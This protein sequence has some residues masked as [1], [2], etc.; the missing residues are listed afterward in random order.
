MDL[1]QQLAANFSLEG[2]FPLLA[3]VGVILTLMTAL[4]A[5]KYIKNNKFWYYLL[6]L[7]Y[8]I[9]TIIIILTNDWF[10]FLF[11]WE[12]VTLA[13]T[14]M[15]AWSDWKL[16]RQYFVIQ[17]SGSSIL[18][19]A[20]LAANGLGYTD[21]TVIESL[22]LQFLLIMGIG[23][24]SGLFLF[25]FWLPPIHSEAPSPVSAVLS[26]WVV[27]LGYIFLL[28]IIP[29]E[30]GNTFLFL[31]G[32]AMVAYAGWQ[33]LVSADFKIML[34]YST[35]S[36]LGFIA[37]AI[38]TGGEYTY[39]GAVLYIIA[40]GFAKTTLFISTGIW[41]KEFDSRII[42][43]YKDAL[44]R[45]PFT[46]IAT[47]T[48]LLSLGGL[49]FTAGYKSK[50]LIKSAQNPGLLSTIVFFVFGL[51]SFLYAARVIY[52][53]FIDDQ[54]YSNFFND[55]KKRR[56]NYPIFS[57]DLL[58]L[59][60]GVLGIASV[61]IW[62][63]MPGQ[64]LESLVA[65]DFH[66]L[67]GIRDTVLFLLLTAYIFKNNQFFKV[68][69]RD[70]LSLE[71]YFQQTLNFIYGMS[72]KSIKLDTEKIFETF[73]IEAIFAASRTLRKFIYQDFTVQ[74]LWIPI[75]L[76]LLLFWQQIYAYF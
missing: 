67:S 2:Y 51:L 48:A 9:S 49:V 25:H 36:Q 40:H 39:L 37:L 64:I 50:Y 61:S 60:I 4:A 35:V 31:L 58:A 22:P 7:I 69:A 45:R 65:K 55:L 8:L 41:Q 21:I 57:T 23:M 15:L 74:L 19:F 73:F 70:N 75:F 6:T 20:A 28:K 66:I 53:I 12:L 27:K 11:S 17:F 63:E 29:M 46:S 68:K 33:A 5:W 54:D 43:D 16:V 52:W 26:G 71:N 59:L 32:M 56:N 34:A 30:S 13:T 38:G 62:P 24:K 3:E 47:I 1:F 14:F 10:F 42:Y 72:R 44:A 18:L 76:T